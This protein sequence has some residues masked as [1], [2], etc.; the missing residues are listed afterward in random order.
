MADGRKNNGGHK[1]AGRKSKAEEQLL[2][3]KLSPLEERAHKALKEAIEDNQSWAVKMYFE[4][5]YGKPKEK[6]EIEFPQGLPV[7]DMSQWK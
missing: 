4:Y 7:V 5:M 3:E 6:K 2:I 1:T